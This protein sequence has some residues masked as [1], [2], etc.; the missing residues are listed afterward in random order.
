MS[1]ADG[2]GHSPA[3]LPDELHDLLAEARQAGFLGP[4]PLDVQLGHAAGF[5]VLARR[6]ASDAFEALDLPATPGTPCPRP[7]IVDLGSGG[8]LPG[9]VVAAAWPEGVV[10][11]L[12]AN[13]R[14]T[15]FLRRAVDRLGLGRTGA[16]SS[17]SVRSSTGAWRE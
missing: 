17:R 11:L 2:A 15:E 14:R 5:A 1:G 12:D 13:A 4:G 9:L 3:D 6:L 16:A 7:R 8:G 10:V